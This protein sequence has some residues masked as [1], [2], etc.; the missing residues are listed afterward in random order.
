MT[1]NPQ[2]SDH[3][4]TPDAP[5]YDQARQIWNARYTATPSAIIYCQNANGV[6][7]PQSIS[8]SL[9]EEEARRLNLPESMI[10]EINSPD[11]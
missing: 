7:F 1:E 3:V 8:V 2:P 11:A 9:T 4:V 10:A 6:S 5:A